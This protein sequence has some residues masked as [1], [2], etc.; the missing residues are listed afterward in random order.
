MKKA[1]KLKY[2][3]EAV[4]EAVGL[5]TLVLITDGSQPVG[6]RHRSGAGSARRSAKCAE[7]GNLDAPEDLRQSGPALP[8]SCLNWP[9]ICVKRVKE[10][11]LAE[12]NHFLPEGP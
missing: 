6:R 9:N 5:N 3:F 1:L 12:G 8:A 10:K 7:G 4:G 2:Y 11:E